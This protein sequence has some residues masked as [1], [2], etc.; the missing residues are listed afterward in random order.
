[1][2]ATTKKTI[3]YAAQVAMKHPGLSGVRFDRYETIVAEF[4]PLEC[5]KAIKE[6]IKAA[7][8]QKDP[9]CYRFRVVQREVTEKNI[10]IYTSGSIYPSKIKIKKGR[11]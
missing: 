6:F 3:S 8:E 7:T 2:K 1:M 4:S 11:Q 5:N 9:A 10:I